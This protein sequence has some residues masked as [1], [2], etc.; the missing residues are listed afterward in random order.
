MNNIMAYFIFLAVTD[1]QVLVK[2]MYWAGGLCLQSS[3]DGHGKLSGHFFLS[4]SSLSFSLAISSIV[5]LGFL[6]LRLADMASLVIDGLN[7][8]GVVTDVGAIFCFS[9]CG[10]V[11]V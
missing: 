9:L 4:S 11:Q 6:D 5:Y 8:V 3:S 1:S 10:R 2:T 7:D